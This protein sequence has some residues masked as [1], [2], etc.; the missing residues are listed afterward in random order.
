MLLNKLKFTAQMSIVLTILRLA[1]ASPDHVPAFMDKKLFFT[2]DSFLHFFQGLF[3]KMI[4]TR[5]LEVFLFMRFFH[6]THADNRAVGV[7]NDREQQYLAS[8]LR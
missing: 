7:H 8:Q 1:Y 5:R 2:S 4:C 6:L 3:M